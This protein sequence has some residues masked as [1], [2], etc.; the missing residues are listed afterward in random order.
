MVTEDNIRKGIEEKKPP[1]MPNPFVDVAEIKSGEIKVLADNTNEAFSEHLRDKYFEVD[2]TIDFALIWTFAERPFRDMEDRLR[3][4]GIKREIL[5]KK[6]TKIAGEEKEEIVK[7]KVEIRYKSQVLQD[8]ITNLLQ[9]R[10]SLNGRRVKQYIDALDAGNN[11]MRGYIEQ[12][13]REMPVQ[14]RMG[15]IA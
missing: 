3:A 11:R 6:I 10:H 7:E 1:T 9:R 15:R 13:M 12:P 14:G 8:F 4:K 5:V 2:E